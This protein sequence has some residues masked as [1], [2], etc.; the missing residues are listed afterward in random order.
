MFVVIITVIVIPLIVG[1]LF[2]F[3]DDPEFQFVEETH[4]YDDVLGI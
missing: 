3:R 2:G 4:E 1:Y